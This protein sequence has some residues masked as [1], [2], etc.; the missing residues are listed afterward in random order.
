MSLTPAARARIEALA[1]DLIRLPESE[2]DRALRGDAASPLYSILNLGREKSFTAA[3]APFDWVN[4]RADIVLVGV[5][6]GLRQATDALVSLRRKLRDGATIEQAAEEAKAHASFAGMRTLAA[7]LMDSL[8]LAEAFGLASCEAL[9]GSA[10]GR[11]HSTSVLRYPVLNRGKN[12]SGD[13]RIMDR[14]MLRAMVE[15]HLVPELAALPRAW[16]V[17]FGVNALLVLE[18]LV[19]AGELDGDR[20]LGGVLHPSGHQWNR[21]KVQLGTTAGAAALKVPGGRDVLKR[22]AALRARAAA[23]TEARTGV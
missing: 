1:P 2:I 12:F 4:E 15:E 22:S 5:T 14:P 19:V 18:A 13:K 3:Y 11:V 9:F 20:V 23:I 8:G 6:P 17:P 7:R 21:Y 16:I 10:A